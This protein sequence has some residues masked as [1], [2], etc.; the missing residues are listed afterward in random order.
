MARLLRV[1]QVRPEAWSPLV[2]IQPAGE[3]PPFFCVH[4]AGGI[5][6]C[7]NELAS[8]LGT[9]RP[10]Y[11]FQS[12]GLEDDREPF[13]RLEDMAAF[14]VDALRNVRPVGPYH[15]GGWSLGGVVAFEMARQ[16][17]AQGHEVGTLAL[18]D[19][20]APLGA[21][22]VIP[23]ALKAFAREVA[24]L[25][26]LG[27][28]DAD[29][30]DDALVLAE[31]AGDLVRDSGGDARKLIKHLKGMPLDARRA[32]LL[33][34]FKLDLVYN[35]ETGPERVGRL[36]SVL[37]ANLLAGVRYRP[38]PYP[39][40]VVVF[41]ARDTKE[42]RTGEP[43]LGWSALAAGGVTIHAVP[44]DHAGILKGRGAASL[45]AALRVELDRKAT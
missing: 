37:R 13:S 18:L 24:A 26:L 6:Y 43:T 5:V 35:H 29:P 16:L 9:A 41:R 15:L 4:P 3:E 28:G 39:G 22:L 7:F 44:G 30:L 19:T 17:V 42:K 20:T 25:G 34:A 33:K 2:A 31:F 23:E 40:R 1:E 27:P 45:A 10:F 11:A 36:W 14:Y 21:A 38:E 8:Q 32:Y 12:A